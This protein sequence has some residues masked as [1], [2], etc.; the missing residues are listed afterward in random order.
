MKGTLTEEPFYSERSQRISDVIYI[1]LKVFKM[2][3]LLLSFKYR[4]LTRIFFFLELL[5]VNAHSFR[6]VDVGSA[7][8]FFM[9]RSLYYGVIFLANFF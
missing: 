6:Y 8:F 4:K 9:N 1:A 2:V 3:L 7:G 5:I